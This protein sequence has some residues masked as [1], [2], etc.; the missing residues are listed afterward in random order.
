[1][2]N[3]KKRCEE[4]LPVY[5][6]RLYQ[7]YAMSDVGINWKSCQM[8][9]NGDNKDWE[10][11]S[12]KLT[13]LNRAITHFKDMTK[14]VL[15]YP[16]D[17]S[18]PLVDMY[19]IDTSGKLIGIQATMG[20][21]HPKSLSVYKKFYELIK[22]SPENVQLNLYYLILPRNI[23]SFV[24]KSNKESK[25][26]SAI[27]SGGGIDLKWINNIQFYLLLPPDTFEATY[28]EAK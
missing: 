16:S 3:G 28:P 26:F 18:F 17:R 23:D 24:Q 7:L 9:L 20:K 8:P 10:P 6:E 22:T 12:M 19:F 4:K 2:N 13:N 11:C 21:A 27:N 15:Y 14:D 1:V 5:L 25:F